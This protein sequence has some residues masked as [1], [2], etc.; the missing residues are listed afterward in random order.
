MEYD[1]FVENL[2]ALPLWQETELYI[3]EMAPGQRK[4]SRRLVMAVVSDPGGEGVGDDV[5]WLRFYSG[6]RHPKSLAM[7]VTQEL[8]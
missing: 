7:K 4:Y 2:G 3:R 1:T 8:G 6:R 5:L